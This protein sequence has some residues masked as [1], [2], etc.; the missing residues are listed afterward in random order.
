LEAVRPSAFNNPEFITIVI[1]LALDSLLKIVF[2][3]MTVLGSF[4]LAYLIIRSAYPAFRNL[5]KRW[6][7]IIS[8]G[9]GILMGMVFII[10]LIISGNLEGFLLFLTV[11][12]LVL[13]G[14]SALIGKLIS[15]SGSSFTGKESIVA[16]AAFHHADVTIDDRLKVGAMKNALEQTSKIEQLKTEMETA[17]HERQNEL[18]KELTRQKK[19]AEHSLKESRSMISQIEIREQK[20]AILHRELMMEKDRQLAAREAMKSVEKSPEK[21]MESDAASKPSAKVSALLKKEEPEKIVKPVKPAKGKVDWQWAMHKTERAS[22]PGEVTGKMQLN[23][24]ESE[25]TK[26]Q[27]P[28]SSLLTPAK[29]LTKIP[30][31]QLKSEK[32]QT[33]AKQGQDLEKLDKEWKKEERQEAKEKEMSEKEYKAIE[34]LLLGEDDK[35]AGKKKNTKKT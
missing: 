24:G 21:F 16:E 1:S 2:A 13:W 20:Q 33:A 11:S 9:G 30:P 10:P 6:K 27:K 23:A 18:L 28:I 15:R 17:R 29:K 14:V 8:A 26:T 19:S 5:R 25:K 34:S 32:I 22:I 12:F 3:V 7:M 35:D 31:K 4:P